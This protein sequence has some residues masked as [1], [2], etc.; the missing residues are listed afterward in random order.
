MIYMLNLRTD[1]P[2]TRLCVCLIYMYPAVI[3]HNNGKSKK[4]CM[5][6][7]LDAPPLKVSG[8]MSAIFAEKYVNSRFWSYIY[9]YTYLYLSFS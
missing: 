3:Q 5:H 8:R 7:D 6:I 9:I 4:L 1:T 2:L